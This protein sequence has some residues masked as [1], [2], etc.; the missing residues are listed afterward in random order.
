MAG[1]LSN[2]GEIIQGRFERPRHLKWMLVGVGVGVGVG[3]LLAP[4]TDR[5]ARKNVSD[6]M[7]DIGGR[8]RDRLQ[9][10]RMRATGTEGM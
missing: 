7:H 9:A 8:V 6:K 4:V 10:D 3:M 5:E 2:T 1:R